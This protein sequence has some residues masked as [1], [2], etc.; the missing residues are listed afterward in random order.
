MQRRHFNRHL[1]TSAASLAALLVTGTLQHARALSLSDLSDKEVGSGLKAAL[2][3]GALAAVALLGQSGGFLDNPKVRIPLPAYL[4]EAAKLLRMTGQ[5]KPVDELVTGMNRAAEA[6]VPMGRDLLVKAVKSMTVQDAK[7][8]LSGGDDAV[9]RFF[10]DKTRAPLGQSFLPVVTQAVSKVGLAKS[11]N[12]VAGKAAG[13][14]LVKQEEASV[15]QYVTGK[16]LDGLYT[17]IGEEERKIRQDPV[18]A[19]SRLIEKVFG[20]VK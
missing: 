9:T 2:E 15:E 14:G 8:I 3:K 20:A 17:I 16:T 7:Q 19:G 12:R 13:F 10:A 18:G 1:A 4:E 6:A 5:G 11:Y